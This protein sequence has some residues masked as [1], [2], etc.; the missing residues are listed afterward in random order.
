MNRREPTKIRRYRLGP[1][2]RSLVGLCKPLIAIYVPGLR[3]LDY[4][5]I[6]IT[7]IKIM[8]LTYWQFSSGFERQRF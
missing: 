4:I 6:R 7:Y 3:H 2:R 5:E 1:L 8:M